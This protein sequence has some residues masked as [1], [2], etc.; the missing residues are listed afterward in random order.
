MNDSTSASAK[1]LRRLLIRGS[2]IAGA[3]MVSSQVIRLASNLVLSRL[4]FPQAFGLLAIVNIV[5]QGLVMF[6]DAGLQAAVIQ[7]ERG[8]DQRFLDTIFTWQAVRGVFLWLAACALSWPLAHFYGEPMLRQLIPV[9]SLI[10][11]ILGFQS[12]ATF[13]LRKRLSLVPLVSFELGT[14]VVGTATM[15]AWSLVSPSPWALV[16]GALVGACATAVGSHFLSVGYRNRFAWDRQSARAMLDFGK[17]VAGSSM[18]TFISGQGDRLIVGYYLGTSTL[19]VYSIAVFLSGAVGEVLSRISSSV[20]FPA[21]SRVREQGIA[22]LRAAYY[23]T[24]LATDV[25]ALPALGALSVLGT[26]TVDVLYDHRYHTAGWMLQVL[27]ARVALG[28]I[29]GPR[30][31]CLMSLGDTRTLFQQNLARGLWLVLAV[32]AGHRFAGVAGLVWAAALSE[33]AP[34]GV[35]MVAF[36]RKGL[37][38]PARE[39]LSPVLFAVGVLLGLG[40]RQLL[41]LSGLA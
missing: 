15:I 30:Q 5:N 3:G 33:L 22:A 29:N 2:A 39:L 34:L 23:K 11:V 9:G 41:V 16:G 10:V 32:P 31:F 27:T 14:Q 18:L 26:F 1:G 38:R 20:L 36:A 21:Y 12:T 28:A 35:L 6:S 17:W 19:G 13:T 24:R 25:L 7:S 8:E 37:L 40:V 4:L